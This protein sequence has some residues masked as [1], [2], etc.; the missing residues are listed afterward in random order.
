MRTIRRPNYLASCHHVQRERVVY[1]RLLG[2]DETVRRRVPGGD[3]HTEERNDREYLLDTCGAC[4]DGGHDTL[5]LIVE[6]GNRVFI[7]TR[8]RALIRKL[9]EFDLTDFATA[10]SP[11]LF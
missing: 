4:R 11:A 1:N 9:V 5:G 3:I 8:Q 6:R 10:F 7:G 2:Q